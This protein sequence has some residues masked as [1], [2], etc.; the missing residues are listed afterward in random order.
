[1]VRAAH[2]TWGGDSTP[3]CRSRA[4]ELPAIIFSSLSIS[5]IFFWF[6][7]EVFFLEFDFGIFLPLSGL[8]PKAHEPRLPVAAAP[9][10]ATPPSRALVG[11]GPQL[12]P[13]R[14]DGAAVRRA[15]AVGYS[16]PPGPLHPGSGMSRAS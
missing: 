8:P 15:P 4:S 5:F 2:T 13:R 11:V 7:N 1:L 14:I 12:L 6:F 9:R 10:N 3:P 16:W